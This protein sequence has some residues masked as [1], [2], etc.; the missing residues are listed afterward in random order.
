MP[1]IIEIVNS[2]DTQLSQLNATGPFL[3]VFDEGGDGWMV[4][5]S[6][7]GGGLI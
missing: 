4:V 6:G 2:P 3:N 5:V 7:V 1:G